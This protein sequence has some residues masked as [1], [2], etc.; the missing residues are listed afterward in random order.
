MSE[1]KGWDFT[2]KNNS[3]MELEDD[4]S[5]VV[6]APSG[7]MMRLKKVPMFTTGEN[8][9]D[10]KTYYTEGYSVRTQILCIKEFVRMNKVGLPRMRHKLKSI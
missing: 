9:I 2:W 8:A 10:H 7:N 3:S 4:E 6:K 1:F 5:M